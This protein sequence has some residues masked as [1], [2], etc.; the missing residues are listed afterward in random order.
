MINV[1]Y[2]TDVL[3]GGVDF[4][5]PGNGGR[6]CVDYLTPQQRIV[7]TVVYELFTIFVFWK[8]LGTVSFP[9]ELPAYREGTGVGKRF[10]LVLLCLIFG[11]EIGFKFATKQVIFLLNPCH[12]ITAI[13]IYLLAVPPSKRVL[14]VFRIHIYLLFGALQ[15]ILFPVVNTRLLPF[16]VATYWIQHILIFIIV[17]FFLISCQGPFTLEPVCDFTW[18]TLTFTLVSFYHLLVLQP[19]GMLLHVN[20][21]NMVCPAVSDPFSGP[22][23]RIIACCHQPAMIFLIGKLFCVTGHKFVDLLYGSQPKKIK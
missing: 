17:P 12:V 7:E 20:L 4:A 5:L 3:Y 8:M 18:A 10:I 19:L 13:Q 22:Y 6:E 16:E 15:A 9:R 1:N 14:C 2:I 21:N 23:Y 11:I